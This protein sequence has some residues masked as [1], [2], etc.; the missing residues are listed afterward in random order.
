MYLHHC[1]DNSS[2]GKLFLTRE[3]IFCHGTLYTMT[4]IIYVYNYQTVSYPVLKHYHNL[5]LIQQQCSIST[6]TQTE[7]MATLETHGLLL[8][9]FLKVVMAHRAGKNRDSLIK[10]L[11][12]W[13]GTVRK[14]NCMRQYLCTTCRTCHA[15]Y[16]YLD[17]A[18]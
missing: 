7:G 18:M 11:G 14:Q 6:H 13:G 4:P 2:S 9:S 3:E 10:L 16:T 5:V 15:M 8:S 12:T 17:L 1:K